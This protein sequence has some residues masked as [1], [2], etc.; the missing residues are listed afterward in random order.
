MT[1][2]TLTDDLGAHEDAFLALEYR[3]SRP[4]GQFVFGDDAYAIE[5][6]DYLFAAGAC[7]FSPPDG[8]V[9]LSDGRAAG[10]ISCL[11]GELLRDYRLQAAE[12]LAESHFLRLDPDLPRR[13][14]LAAGTLLRPDD[15]DFYLSRI[16]VHPDFRGGGIG[17]QLLEHVLAAAESNR[18][19]RCVLE[20]APS[21]LAAVSLYTKHGFEETD[22]AGVVDPRTQRVLEYVHM[23]RALG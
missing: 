22:R 16:A 19:K 2:L 6:R 15:D 12:E 13:L 8:L 1:A 5:V 14:Q 11:H 23:A 18:C 17:S 10:M 9:A 7:E 21:A 3:A 4:Y 20:V